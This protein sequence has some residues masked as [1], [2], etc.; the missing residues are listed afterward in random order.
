M[1]IQAPPE[2]SDGAF[3]FAGVMD[4]KMQG[5][6]TVLLVDEMGGQAVFELDFCHFSILEDDVIE[7]S[8]N[9]VARYAL[10]DRT[11]DIN[12]V[13]TGWIKKPFD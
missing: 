5:L 6:L 7:Y 3:R 1:N 4:R 2:R 8:V 10:L 9:K 13:R 12:V 11:D